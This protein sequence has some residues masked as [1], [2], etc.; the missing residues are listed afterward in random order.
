MLSSAS[1]VNPHSW[2]LKSVRAVPANPQ[3]SL[4]LL[5]VNFMTNAAARID[6]TDDDDANVHS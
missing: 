1:Y 3:W 4:Y 5:I 2:I 6:K